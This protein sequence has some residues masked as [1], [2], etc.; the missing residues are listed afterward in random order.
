MHAS[1]ICLSFLLN[2]AFDM[3]TVLVGYVWFSASFP[4]LD[5]S[6]DEPQNNVSLPHC[7]VLPVAF[8][9]APFGYLQEWRQHSLTPTGRPKKMNRANLSPFFTRRSNGSSVNVGTRGT[10]WPAHGTA[11]SASAPQEKILET[12]H[13]RTCPVPANRKPVFYQ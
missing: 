12:L 7:G 2:S 5:T 13:R 9:V 4:K 1:Y 10:R 6:M 11:W 8:L 3:K